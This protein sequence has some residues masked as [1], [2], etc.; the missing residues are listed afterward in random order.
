MEFLVAIERP[1][2]AKNQQKGRP[3]KKRSR[4]SLSLAI[5]FLYNTMT[6][7]FCTITLTIALCSATQTMAQANFD[8]NLPIVVVE[9]N[10]QTILDE[11]KIEV[12]FKIVNNGPGLT[13]NPAGPFVFDGFAGIETRGQ[14]SQFFSD[15]KPYGI[16]LHDAAGNELASKLL[17]MP[18]ESDWVLLSP[19]SDKSLI[20]DVL[21]FEFAR[22]LDNMAYAPRTRM[23][24]L[25]IN[26]EYR[27][28][29]VL[30]EKIKRDDDRVDIAKISDT[31]PSGG[32]IIKLDKGQWFEGWTSSYP[33][34]GGTQGQVIGIY[35]Q[36]PKPAKITQDQKDYIQDF[37]H[38]M[39]TTL[40]SS[41]FDNPTTGYQKYIDRTSFIDFMLG[42]EIGRNVDG[43]RIST[44][45]YKDR[46]T[47]GQ[48]SHLHAGPAWD[49]NIAFGN[50][51]YCQA[52]YTSGWAWNFNSICPDDNWLIPFWWSRLRQDTNFL[53]ETQARWHELRN[54]TLSNGAVTTFIDS[55]AALVNNGPAGRNFQKWPILGTWQWPNSF[56]GATHAQEIDYLRN[57]T[58]D[59]LNWMDGAI[60]TIY[61]DVGVYIPTDYFEP[62]VFPNPVQSGHELYTEF[63]LRVDDE[64]N[65]RIIDIHGRTVAESQV[66]PNRHGKTNHSFVLPSLQA[67]TYTVKMGS[68]INGN[69]SKV[70]KLV[71]Y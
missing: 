62:R 59:R 46:D 54:T 65:I 41:N 29:Y 50:A 51:N 4:V 58:I 9:T 10:G 68:R 3:L 40:K 2:F 17:G 66:S 26:G 19:F 52:E 30:T 28:V 49:F 36:Y 60:K 34:I 55:L 43:Y 8:S 33:P 67:G 37:V 56:V 57:W 61:T 25:V 1:T 45:F 23:V 12:Q 6:R 38:D 39:E 14:T 44:Y 70:L 31:D 32:H 64:I 24:E 21:A 69:N 18:K 35:H 7:F 5:Q 22:R 48:L 47:M 27:G 71:I 15:K 63:Y 16:E 42:N 20:R 13:N 53:I 11:P